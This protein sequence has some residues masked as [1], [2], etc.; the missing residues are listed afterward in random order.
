[1]LG[2]VQKPE[3]TSQMTNPSR[4]NSGCSSFFALFA[5]LTGFANDG[6]AQSRLRMEPFGASECFSTWLWGSS[7]GLTSIDFLPLGADLFPRSTFLSF[8]TLLLLLPFLL[9][10]S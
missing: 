3:K 9:V 8:A 6:M 10:L 7:R 5:F 1:M 4:Q 2:R